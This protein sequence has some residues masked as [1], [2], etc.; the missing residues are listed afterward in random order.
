MGIQGGKLRERERAGE[1]E[2]REG[3]KPNGI[4]RKI[5]KTKQKKRK[6]QEASNKIINT[7]KTW[8]EQTQEVNKGGKE[9]WNKDTERIKRIVRQKL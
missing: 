1:K 9:R 5:K 6:I 3:K 4:E 7:T 8:K 2:R